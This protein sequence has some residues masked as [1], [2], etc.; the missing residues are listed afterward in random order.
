VLVIA[1]VLVACGTAYRSDDT[2]LEAL[3]ARIKVEPHGSSSA[4]LL[5]E[6]TEFEWDRV[7]V[8]L[9]FAS[10]SEVRQSLGFNWEGLG[11][12]G[13]STRDDI[14][15]LVFVSKRHVA[16]FVKFPRRLGDFSEIEVPEGLGPS[17]ARFRV[18]RHD[19]RTVV[20]LASG[21]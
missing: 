8:F 6:L 17:E 16:R 12:T 10:D 5:D 15:L 14:V 18:E 11:R 9:P 13:I 19:S 3:A 2:L 4:F 1:L 21:T 20:R 7:F